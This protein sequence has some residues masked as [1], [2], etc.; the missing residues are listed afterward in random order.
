MDLEYNLESMD[1]LC[2]DLSKC[3]AILNNTHIW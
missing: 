3:P 1:Q 2:L